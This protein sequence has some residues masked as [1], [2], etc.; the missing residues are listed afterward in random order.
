[1]IFLVGVV[2]VA[3]RFGHG[4]SLLAC[5]LSLLSF[6]YFFET[7]AFTLEVANWPNLLIFCAMLLIAQLVAELVDRLQDQV[8]TVQAQAAETDALYRLSLGLSQATLPEE[9]DAVSRKQLRSTFGE[10]VAGGASNLRQAFDVQI[11]QA[12]DRVELAE[13]ARSALVEAERERTRSA[14]L[15]AVSHDLRTPLAAIQGA[16][17]SLLLKDEARPSGAEEDLLAM[18]VDESERLTRL[19][20]NLVDMTRLESGS[21]SLRKEWQAL[22]ELIGAVLT[23]LEARSGPLPVAVKLPDDLPLVRIDGVL[24]EQLLINLV[25]NA[26]RHA[27]GA[28]VEISARHENGRLLLDVSDRGPGVPRDQQ[29]RVFDKFVRMPGGGDGGVGLGLAICRAIAQAHGG[30]IEALPREGGGASFRV[31]LPV[32]TEAP[33]APA[34]EE[35]L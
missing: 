23:R 31:V 13:R 10:E 12:R 2:A 17:S 25:E 16:A 7:P 6:D 15:S 28:P 32:E 33:L 3:W 14:L 11:A 27:P 21:T 35:A 8:R 4:A 20:T 18:I 22:E 34:E 30:S 26:L 9:V 24:M 19:V 5:I 29:D 1:M